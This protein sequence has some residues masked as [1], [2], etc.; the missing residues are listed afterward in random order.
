MK[1]LFGVLIF[2]AGAF[3]QTAVYPGGVVTD[4]QLAVAANGISTTLLSSMTV[5]DTSMSVVSSTGIVPNMLLTIGTAVGSKEIVMV[6]SVVGKTV[7]IGKVTCPS[8]N[9]R[10]FDNSVIT[11][12]ATGTPVQ[13]LIDAWHHNAVTAEIKA[14]EANVTGPY[15]NLTAYGAKCDGATDDTAALNSAIVAAMT[16]TGLLQIPYSVN[17][18]LIN[19]QI[20]LPNNGASPLPAQHHLKIVGT[21]PDMSYSSGGAPLAG[22]ATLDMR[23]QGATA[24]LVTLGFGTL[25]IDGVNFK[26][27]GSTNSTPFIFTTN[28]TLKVSND[29]F[30][31][32]CAVPA[33]CTQDAIVLGGSGTTV[34]NTT[35]NFFQGYG[36]VIRDSYFDK[37]QR[38]ALLQN[39]ANNIVIRD[40]VVSNACGGADVVELTGTAGYVL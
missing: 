1:L 39:A 28:T 37:I 31:G 4:S 23:Y 33:A 19:S 3:A 2:A 22:K 18:C 25:M 32:T 7:N 29:S 11:V 27:G 6:C 26:D 15:L 10:G 38:L 12:H 20:V 16:T 21:V 9:G 24:K 36:T 30:T 13:A 14:I 34:G 8:L 5:G 40:N 35:T 17:G